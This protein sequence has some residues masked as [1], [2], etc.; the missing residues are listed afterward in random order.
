MKKLCMYAKDQASR[1]GAAGLRG[2]MGLPCSWAALLEQQGGCRVVCGWIS[3]QV[4]TL[5]P[6]NCL[7]SLPG[8]RPSQMAATSEMSKGNTGGGPL[9]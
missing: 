9:K 2:P 1:L 7:L 8:T 4:E 6:L 3:L 5:L